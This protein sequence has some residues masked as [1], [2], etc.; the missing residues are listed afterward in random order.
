[1]CLWHIYEIL[2]ISKKKSMLSSICSMI[3]KIKWHISGKRQKSSG[4]A[5]QNVQNASEWNF[6][7]NK[8]WLTILKWQELDFW[9]LNKFRI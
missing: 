7:F 2:D 6:G 3:H 4:N 9:I 5:K 8:T 1:M